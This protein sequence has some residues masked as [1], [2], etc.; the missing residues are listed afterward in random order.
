MSLS[1]EGVTAQVD[2][3]QWRQALASAGGERNQ[4]HLWPVLA[5]GF[6]DLVARKNAQVRTLAAPEVCPAWEDLHHAALSTHKHLQTRLSI[7]LLQDAALQ[8]HETRLAGVRQAV[9][10]LQRK[11]D[12]LLQTS[13]DKVQP[14]KLFLVLPGP[15]GHI[16]ARSH[17]CRAAC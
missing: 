15:A 4:R 17:G 13:L 12:A 3:L 9:A 6:R 5:V 2:A 14:R 10:E 8:E 11:Q 16:A 7:C 1:T